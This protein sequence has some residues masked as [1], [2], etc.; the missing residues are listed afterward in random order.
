MG[1]ELFYADGQVDM[2]KLIVAFRNYEKAS[3]NV[4]YF[5]VCGRHK[6]DNFLLTLI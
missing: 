5:S 6:A 4:I 1:A 2:M 3:D